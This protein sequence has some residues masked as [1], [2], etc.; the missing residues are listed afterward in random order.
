MNTTA[1]II[2]TITAITLL[3]MLIKITNLENLNFNMA[4]IAGVLE[5]PLLIMTLVFSFMCYKTS[6]LV[7]DDE[8]ITTFLIRRFIL[9]LFYFFG[10]LMMFN[11]SLFVDLFNTTD[12]RIVSAGIIIFISTTYMILFDSEIKN[13]INTIEINKGE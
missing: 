9:I 10:L 2:N 11:N 5:Y 8:L 4:V 7:N 1:K 6:N 12:I 13:P 3:I